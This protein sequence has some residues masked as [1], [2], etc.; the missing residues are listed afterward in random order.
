MR[1]ARWMG[2]DRYVLFHLCNGP[3]SLQSEEMNVLDI[4][5]EAKQAL[6]NG[7]VCSVPCPE[8]R[9]HLER[10]SYYGYFSGALPIT[11]LRRT[12]KC[13]QQII[14]KETDQGRE[15]PMHYLC[16]PLG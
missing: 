7:I 1:A 14:V 4:M 2:F 9:C 3:Q 15:Q 11:L 10:S 8:V 6:G 12:L 5:L 16:L 13:L